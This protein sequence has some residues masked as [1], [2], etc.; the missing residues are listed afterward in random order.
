LE[1]RF[2][3][4]FCFSFSV[5]FILKSQSPF[6][7]AMSD[8]EVS[9]SGISSTSEEGNRLKSLLSLCPRYVVVPPNPPDGIAFALTG[10]A[11]KWDHL[12]YLHSGIS[13]CKPGIWKAEMKV[14]EGAE[15]GN[16][17]REACLRWV[18][19][20][21][22]ET[23]LDFSISLNEWQAWDQM[24]KDRFDDSV[25]EWDEGLAWKHAG[26]YYDDGGLLNVL[27]TAYLTHEAAAKV[28]EGRG[29][30]EEDINE[31]EWGGYLEHITLNDNPASMEDRIR[32]IGFTFGGLHCKLHLS[33][34][35]CRLLT[36]RYC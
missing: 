6:T 24:F 14:I 32:N 15:L 16:C 1:S 20:L 2:A 31:G 19:G 17:D 27:S 35:R 18:A 23:E 28:L 29:A 11:Q 21:D 30:G 7:A 36:F 33:H 34:W 12:T 9:D 8:S 5:C 22:E 25:A 13:N 4:C 10:D 26:T 3:H